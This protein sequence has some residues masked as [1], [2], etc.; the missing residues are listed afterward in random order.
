MTRGFFP[1]LSL[2]LLLLAARP[3]AAVDFVHDVA[4][5]LK[6]HCSE[7]HMGDKHKGGY[8]MNTRE[9]MLTP[10]D[11]GPM[12]IAGKSAESHIIRLI[13]SEDEDERMPPKGAGLQAEEVAI[14]RAWIDAGVPWEKGFTFKKNSYEAPLKLKRA[15]LPVASKS[16][17]THPIDRII[18]AYFVAKNQPLPA[19]LDDRAFFRR[20]HLDLIGT[21]PAPADLEAFLGDSQPNKRQQLIQRLLDDREAYTAHWLSFWNDLLRN[22]YAGTG[23]IDGGRRSISNW[24]YLSLFD[25]KPYDVMARELIAPTAE[26]DGFSKGIKWRGQISAGQTIP[27]QFAQS[28]GQAFLGINL[29]CASCHDSF[30]D[31][32]KLTDSYGL[33]A[34]FSAQPI[35]IARCDKPT[36]VTAQPY[37]LFPELGSIDASKPPAERLK[38]IAQLTTHPDNGHFSR[39]IVNRL[40]FRLMGRGI[41]HPV[42][43][44]TNPPWNE[45]LLDH[46]AAELVDHHYDLKH[47]LA[48]ICSSRAYQS[49]A[50]VRQASDTAHWSYL[51]PQAKRLTAEQF[52]DAVWDLCDAKPEKPDFEPKPVG[53]QP[54]LPKQLVVRA[55][56]MKSDLFMRSLGRP[57][58]EQIVCSRPNELTTLEAMDFNNGEILDKLLHRGADHWIAT[59]PNPVA[60]VEQLYLRVLTRRPTSTELSTAQQLLGSKPQVDAVHDLMWSLLML[61][62][63]Q[64]IR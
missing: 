57:N 41:V 2:P 17:R 6:K 32:W 58:R 40:W 16:S 37:Y 33:A 48:H 59:S 38:Q 21:L 62:E 3:C 28:V 23:Y 39:T 55:S 1:H 25:N 34:A 10:N 7:C 35:E 22:D 49:Q 64:I 4:P 43:A 24:L 12:V 51:G 45:A 14:I 44:M 47:L 61:P 15:P 8:A 11:D 53:N 5:L 27:I 52:I 20:L 54:A 19:E 9:E 29:K 50:E 46:L 18:D 36:G 56:L 63:F 26:S 30:T 13:T 31:R 42:D 60:L